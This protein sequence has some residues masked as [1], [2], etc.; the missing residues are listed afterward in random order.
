MLNFMSVGV[1]AWLSEGGRGTSGNVNEERLS[2]RSGGTSCGTEGNASKMSLSKMGDGMVD[3]EDSSE[4]QEGGRG[5]KAAPG[6]KELLRKGG[7]VWMGAGG[8]GAAA[9]V[10]CR[11]VGSSITESA[12]VSC[13]YRGG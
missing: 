9:G 3:V 8:E 1:V 6:T 4:T 11:C 10:G 5:D 12:A 7:T 2:P 13:Q